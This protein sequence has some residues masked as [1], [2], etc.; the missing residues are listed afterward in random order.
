MGNYFTDVYLQRMNVDGKNRQERIK[1]RKE[2][3]F[4]KIFLKQS[5]YQVKIQAINDEKVEILGS[6]QPNKWNESELVGNLLISTN[7]RKLRAGEILTIK[8]EIKEQ[9]N[10]R[11]WLILFEEKNLTKGY[12]LYKVICLDSV[13][14]LTDEYGTTDYSFPVKFVNA[15]NKIVQDIFVHSANQPGYREPDGTRFFITSDFDFI[16]KPRYFY[17]KE[18]GWEIAGV[19]N[20]SIENVAFVTITERLL[21]APEALK[22]KDI[23]VG[24]D[25][26]FFLNGG[27]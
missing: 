16:K 21:R 3:E 11:Y 7:A 6:L 8:W 25:T 15:T 27:A 9:E 13:V 4:N 19:D 5:E 26:N 24:E 20:I 22:S 23:I 18:R 1:T 10:N 14:S 17:Y 2:K 12:C